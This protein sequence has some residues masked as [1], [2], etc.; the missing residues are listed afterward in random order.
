MKMRNQMEITSISSFVTSLAA[1]GKAYKASLSVKVMTKSKKVTFLVEFNID[2]TTEFKEF[3]SISDA[4]DF[5][6]NI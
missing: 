3:D 4:V 5:Y 6:N 1:K 2:T